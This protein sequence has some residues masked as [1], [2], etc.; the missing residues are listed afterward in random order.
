[1]GA[2]RGGGGGGGEN[3]IPR[4]Q[5]ALRAGADILEMDLQASAPGPDGQRVAF[6]SHDRELG[7]TTDC[8]GAFDAKTPEEIR[9]CRVR[10]VGA[11]P[12]S[13]AEVLAWCR[14]RA[15]V[16]AE[17]KT[18]DV[19]EPAIR[20][21]REHGAYDWV[22]F[23]TRDSLEFYQRARALDARVAL[24]AAPQGP[25]A[26]EQLERLLALADPRLVVIELH[27]E[28]RTPENLA[29][30]HAAG[31]LASENAWHFGGEWTRW[32]FRRARCAPVFEAGIDIAISKVPED[33][34]RQ[35]DRL[36]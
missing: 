21:V 29:A 7:E 27:P 3:T 5:E 22:Y 11:P 34:V 16:N 4:F 9:R 30:I 13:F 12:P 14:G 25:G 19:I 28:I 31:K 18:R 20:A 26:Q 23:Q 17:F 33:C 8:R 35:R 24:L 6:V 10:G 32:P 1:V 36:R 15:V 2:H